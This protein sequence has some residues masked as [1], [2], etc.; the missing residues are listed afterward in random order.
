MSNCPSC[1]SKWSNREFK[2]ECLD[3]RKYNPTKAKL[4]ATEAKL[5]ATE[6]KLE[7]A[8]A[9]LKQAYTLWPS[10]KPK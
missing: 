3:C 9:K 7:A 8:E 5:Q 10:Y 1:H 6:A 4:E 2:V